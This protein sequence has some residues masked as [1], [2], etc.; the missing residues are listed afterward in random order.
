MM[1]EYLYIIAALAT[2]MLLGTIFFGGLWL[3]VT[4][5]MASKTPALWFM[6]S[7]LLRT[8]IVLT[9]FYY[10]ADG[11][12]KRMLVCLLGFIVARIVVKR[13]LLNSNANL[14]NVKTEITHEA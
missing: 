12:I 1:N 11:N 6:G 9:G 8:A 2:G 10:I 7:F 13:L 5:S 3:T 14:L 4:K